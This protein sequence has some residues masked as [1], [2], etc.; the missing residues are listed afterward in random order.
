MKVYVVAFLFICTLDGRAVGAARVLTAVDE[1]TVKTETPFDSVTVGQRFH[2]LYHFTYADSLKPVVREKLAMGTCRVVAPVAWKEAKNETRIERIGDVTFIPLSV[3]SSVVPANSFDFVSPAGDTIRAWTDDVQVPIRRIAAKSTE[4]RPLKEQWK[5]P[6][7]YWLWAAIGAAVLIAIGVL[8][9]W[10]R[11]RR[12]R[13]GTVAAEAALPPDAVAL[14]ELERIAGMGLAGRGEYKLHYTLVVDTLRR[15]LEAR[16]RVEA[17]DRTSFEIMDALERRGTRIDGLG[18]L[19]DEADLVKFAKFAPDA[20]SATAVIGRAR[21]IVIETTP[22]P[23]V[24][25]V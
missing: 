12:R 23:A 2:V 15:Y 22:A 11:E 25:G 1:I 7:N 5:A 14:A 6:P 24:A 16:Y 3:D 17:M 18:P 13:D 10:L 9:W 19:F 4:L 20:D 21:D 8:V